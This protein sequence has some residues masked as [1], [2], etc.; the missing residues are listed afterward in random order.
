MRLD[1]GSPA[2][3]RERTVKPDACPQ[4]IKTARERGETKRGDEKNEETRCQNAVY[5]QQTATRKEEAV[6]TKTTPELVQRCKV[7]QEAT[8]S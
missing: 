2:H 6:T 4:G 1:N 5:K 3:G 7:E 8:R